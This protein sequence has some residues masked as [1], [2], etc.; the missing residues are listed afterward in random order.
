[1]IAR[2][3][4]IELGALAA[5]LAVIGGCATSGDVNDL[6]DEAATREASV[7]TRS[8]YAQI[9]PAL[10]RLQIGDSRSRVLEIVK[11]K[12]DQFQVV[13]ASYGGRTERLIFN[14]WPGVLTPFNPKAYYASTGTIVE[15]HFGYMDGRMLRPRKILIFDGDHVAKIINYPD[16]TDILLEPGATVVEEKRELLGGIP[17]RDSTSQNR[18]EI[19]KRDKLSYETIFLKKKEIFKPGMNIWEI[20][21]LLGAQYVASNDFQRFAVLCPGLLNKNKRIESTTTVHGLRD[22]YPFGYME[23]D[24]DV[25]EWEIETL[26]KELVAIRKR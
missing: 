1:M 24:K 17:P 2:S 4:R 20:Y 15:M 25:I 6:I 21:A 14:H 23:G 10:E 12:T 3:Y 22:I 9:Q 16:P 19:F 5:F 7:L 26:E 18:K 8:S 13:E 11:P